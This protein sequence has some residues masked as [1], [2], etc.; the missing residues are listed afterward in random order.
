MDGF[1]FLKNSIY[2]LYIIDNSQSH[3]NAQELYQGSLPKSL[4]K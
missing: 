4:E 1:I 3:Y 2:L